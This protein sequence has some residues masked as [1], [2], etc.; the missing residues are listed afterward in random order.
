MRDVE[1]HFTLQATD[2]KVEAKVPA[3]I[4]SGFKAPLLI[5]TRLLSHAHTRTSA[6]PDRRTLSIFDF[7]QRHFRV[8]G[9]RINFLPHW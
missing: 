2:S 9:G 8:R 7:P 6:V 4:D 1:P 3:A 5:Y